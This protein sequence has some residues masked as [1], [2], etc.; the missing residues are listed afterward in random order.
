MSSAFERRQRTTVTRSLA[1]AV[2]G[3][4]L[5]GSFANAQPA[6]LD[7]DLDRPHH[8]SRLIVGLRPGERPARPLALDL[9]EKSAIEKGGV[10][11]LDSLGLFVVRLKLGGDD[12]LRTAAEEI[13]ADPR[14]AFVKPDYQISIDYEMATSEPGADQWALD[15]IEAE[16]AR[17]SIQ[18][19]APVV[20]AVIDTGVATDHPDLSAALW[21]N[22]CE[23]SGNASD[24]R[25]A[26]GR[27]NGYVDDVLGW[28]FIDDNDQPVDVAGHGT[29]VAGVIGAIPDNGVCIDGVAPHAKLMTLKALPEHRVPEDETKVYE[30]PILSAIYYAISEG[31]QILNVS[32]SLQRPSVDM[33]EA[34]RILSERNILV[35]A[36]AGAERFPC[37]DGYPNV[38]CV[39]ATTQEDDQPLG[40]DWDRQKVHLG[41]PGDSVL[42]TDP[43]NAG[44]DCA[45][46][47][48]ASIAAPHV[49]GVAALILSKCSNA[50]LDELI[51]RIVKCTDPVADLTSRT[52]SG[53]RLN[54]RRAVEGVCGSVPTTC[55]Q[56]Y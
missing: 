23:F 17:K 12:S 13:A 38:V 29:N 55:T 40:T 34:F 51:R 11:N 35:V 53:G 5:V 44:I 47:K 26:D 8:P 28:N 7:F 56:P 45:L 19:P 31:A 32:W 2:L 10:R 21:R 4:L 25:C 39:G 20:V 48:E 46:R 42:T 3:T 49:T 9:S 6:R 30:S 54:A 1:V 37:S 52:I 15:R 43:P 50:S 14:V 18:N 22:P 27:S 33:K 36:A 41:A 24:D 16:A